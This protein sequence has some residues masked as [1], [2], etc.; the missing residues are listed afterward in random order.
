MERC[1]PI[2]ELRQYTVLPGTRETLVRVFEEHFL[3]GQEQHGMRIIGQFRDCDAPNRFV[4]IRGFTDMDARARALEA[5]YFG[6]VW[7]AHGPA[8][9][10]TMVDHTDVL[11]LRPA[12]ADAGFRFDPRLRPP[13]D[14]AETPGGLVVATIHHLTVPASRETG[15]AS[16]GMAAMASEMAASMRED[17]GA[18]TALGRF[19][20]EPARNTYPRLPVREDAHVLVAFVSYPTPDAYRPSASASP[21]VARVEHL[22]LQPTRRSFLRHA[23]VFHGPRQGEGAQER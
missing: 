18:G 11:L 10:A 13:R 15:A 1:C 16:P 14:A 19:V 6:P 22:R 7:K 23:S 5:F 9:N 2:V 17:L 21:A 8:A 12:H 4:W 20:T 3:E